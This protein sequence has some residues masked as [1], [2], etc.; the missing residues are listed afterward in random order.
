MSNDSV[1]FL[2]KEFIH[3]ELTHTVEGTFGSS[4][5]ICTNY[6]DGRMVN[7]KIINAADRVSV[8]KSGSVM[9]NILRNCEKITLASY[10]GF[11]FESTGQKSG[12]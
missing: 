7:Q 9:G 6:E 3:N 12:A 10:A 2:M 4:Q 11:F 1:S 8:S 5:L